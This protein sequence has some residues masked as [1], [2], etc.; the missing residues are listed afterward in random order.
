ME[1]PKK[2]ENIEWLEDDFFKLPEYDPKAPNTPQDTG[3]PPKLE[4]ETPRLKES[5]RDSMF[6]VTE[7]PSKKRPRGTDITFLFQF[8]IASTLLVR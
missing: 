7:N 2:Q 6:Q 1:T 4:Q 5:I 8:F 3:A